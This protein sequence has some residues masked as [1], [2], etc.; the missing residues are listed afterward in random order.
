MIPL[1]VCFRFEIRAGL[2]ALLQNRRVSLFIILT[3][4]LGVTLSAGSILAFRRLVLHPLPLPHSEQLH[5]IRRISKVGSS[6]IPLADIESIAGTKLFTAVGGYRSQLMTMGVA[7]PAR[8]NVASVTDGFLDTLGLQ[9]IAGS[10]LD[11]TDPSAAMLD[12][13]FWRAAFGSDRGILGHPLVLDGRAYHIAGIVAA[14]TTLEDR[15]FQV[16]V[17]V[18]HESTRS[19]F[20]FF[21]TIGRL[22]P[23]VPRADAEVALAELFGYGSTSRVS[24][25]PLNRVVVGNTKEITVLVLVGSLGILVASCAVVILFLLGHLL[26]GAQLHGL[27]MRTILGATGLALGSRIIGLIGGLVAPAGVLA[28]GSLLLLER[29][30]R[31]RISSVQGI[32]GLDRFHVAAVAL[33]CLAVVL[34]CF[35]PIFFYILSAR[36]E[37][38]VARAG[39]AA[40][41]E[42]AWLRALML[43]SVVALTLSMSI[44]AGLAFTS[45]S[46]LY[47]RP[48]GFQPNGR[49][50]AVIPTNRTATLGQERAFWKALGERIAAARPGTETGVTSTLPLHGGS[51]VMFLPTPSG[52]EIG[53]ETITASPGLF[54]ALG[55]DIQRGRPFADRDDWSNPPVAILNATAARVMF[56]T[57]DAAVGKTLSLM[58]GPVTIVGV[59]NDHLSRTNQH[60]VRPVAWLPYLQHSTVAT[61]LVVSLGSSDVREFETLIRARVRELDPSRPVDVISLEAL[62]EAP[63]RRPRMAM[64]ALSIFAAALLIFALGVIAANVTMM[65][66]RRARDTAIRVAHG[67][68]PRHIV[69]A[70]IRSVVLPML[71]GLAAGVIGALWLARLLA[72]LFSNV[73][74]FDVRTAVALSV[75]VLALGLVA[76]TVSALT[77]MRRL[78]VW[79]QINGS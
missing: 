69:T 4:W 6:G 34:L 39:R 77:H 51:A 59:S 68:A 10:G 24:L 12:E 40:L 58:T 70:E 55:V 72:A 3:L 43:G 64:Y 20:A 42:S 13:A 79:A 7:E 36:L 52:T 66:R 41:P 47:A 62:V 76:A 17:P 15:P 74:E 44:T 19:S 30:L 50:A 73:Q 38:G 18:S 71:T 32:G 61:A 5:S 22:R 23:E 48:L 11:G 31:L 35:F 78:N 21:T 56:G 2:R 45:V 16:W 25:E 33:P 49:V 29:A 65:L 46:S 54:R 75:G 1:P 53:L 26:S 63:L 37:A 57:V 60:E 14:G 67:A 28:M 9:I 27:I 8:V